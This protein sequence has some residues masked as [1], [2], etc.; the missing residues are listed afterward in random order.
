MYISK[1]ASLA[2]QPHFV[3]HKQQTCEKC[4]PPGEE[5]NHLDPA[6]LGLIILNRCYTYQIEAMVLNQVDD[7][8]QSVAQDTQKQITLESFDVDQHF[9]R[10]VFDRLT[11]ELEQGDYQDF[12]LL[13]MLMRAMANIVIL[14]QDQNEILAKIIA[15][16]LIQKLTKLFSEIPADIIQDKPLKFKRN[17]TLFVTHT[18]R[19]FIVCQS[20]DRRTLEQVPE[21]QRMLRRFALFEIAFP[22]SK[23]LLDCL[24]GD[25]IW[26]K[27]D[28]NKC[29]LHQFYKSQSQQQRACDNCRRV[30]IDVKVCS[31]CRQAYYCGA[32]C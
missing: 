21:L 4:L 17:F 7:L 18:L 30:D 31:R 20:V 24:K 28:A 15:A 5:S 22:L 19:L 12:H 11:Q 8:M 23:R 26:F 10:E 1:N 16:Q 9:L 27:H 3:A 2:L 6:L 25:V 32:Q 13:Q 14:S 29:K